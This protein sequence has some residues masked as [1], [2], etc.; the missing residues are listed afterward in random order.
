MVT[1]VF[2]EDDLLISGQVNIRQV[3]PVSLASFMNLHFCE[4]K[5]CMELKLTEIFNLNF[6]SKGYFA[7]DWF[8]SVM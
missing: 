5:K 6:N 2:V 7:A 8:L 1:E 3:F 4:F